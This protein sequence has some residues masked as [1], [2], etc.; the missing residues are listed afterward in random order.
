MW[1][2]APTPHNCEPTEAA[3]LFA[4]GL[5]VGDG[6]SLP[7]TALPTH[8]LCPPPL[9]TTLVPPGVESDRRQGGGQVAFRTDL[10]QTQPSTPA[11]TSTVGT[12]PLDASLVLHVIGDS[13][14]LPASLRARWDFAQSTDRNRH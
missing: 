10:A 8:S 14:C 11:L 5:R 13:P 7:D 12:Q 3:E 1:G 9:P 4:Q 6:S 2:P